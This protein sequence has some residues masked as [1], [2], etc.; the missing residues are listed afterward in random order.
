LYGNEIPA[1]W[2]IGRPTTITETSVKGSDTQTFVTTR[3]YFSTNNSPDIDQNN[4]GDA[5]WWQLTGITTRLAIYGRTTKPQR[6]YRD[7]Y[8]YDYGT[9][10]V[11]L[12]KVTDPAGT[13]NQLHLR[14]GN[15]AA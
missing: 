15:R 8:N 3:T 14:S 10:G 1:S 5:S 12:M 6:A 2:L 13:E 9:E 7:P 11:N 4:S